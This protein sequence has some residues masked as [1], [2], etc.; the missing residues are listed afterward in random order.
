MD[1][2]HARR[3]TVRYGTLGILAS[4][5]CSE[6]IAAPLP[7]PGLLAQAVPPTYCS[8]DVPGARVTRPLG[9]N[10]R[11]DII[12]LYVDAANLT[13]GFL[14]KGGCDGEL[15]TQD[16][17]G[18]RTTFPRGI[19]NRG[20]VVGR[21]TL[22]GSPIEHGYTMIEGVFATVN[23]PG[24]AQ[25]ALRFINDRGDIAGKYLDAAGKQHGFSL[26]DGV[27][28]TVDFP[29]SRTS[30]L[31]VITNSGIALGD[32]T[33]PVPPP[34]I[35]HG[36]RVERGVITV[37]DVP[38]YTGAT[39]PRWMND[40][41]DVVGIVIDAAGIRH[42]YL[43]SKDATVTLIDYPDPTAL[44]TEVFGNNSRGDITG[45]YTTSIGEHGFLLSR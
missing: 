36:Y 30:D 18:A 45:S 20:D 41:G 22:P 42:G 12:G 35:V 27:F 37:A 21:Y 24:A 9:M 17:P 34:V 29:G 38:G 39:L 10:D 1:T 28:A 32:W 3:L 5:G 2:Q 7:E 23:F 43:M 44:R 6:R 25:S 33:E 31:F 14:L 11:G 16:V 26:I 13:H 8:F 15:S 4:A 19:N 40:R